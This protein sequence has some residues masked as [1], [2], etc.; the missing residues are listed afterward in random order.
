[1]ASPS[2]TELATYRG[3]RA[4]LI[5][6]D[7]SRRRENA[8]LRTRSATEAQADAVL[9]RIRAK[10]AETIWREEHPDIK[11]PFP[12]MEFLTGKRIILQTRV[13]EILSKVCGAFYHTGECLTSVATDA[14]G[15]AAARAPRR[16]RQR[17]LFA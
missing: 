6:D 16:D 5:A 12:G 14:Q 13:F 7:L 10:E 11:H 2:D 15:R 9:R 8:T 17:A 3:A 1:M 4:A